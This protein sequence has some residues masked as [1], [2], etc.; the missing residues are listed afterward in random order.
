M[1]GCCRVRAIGESPHLFGEGP[2]R[3]ARDMRV[4]LLRKVP[5]FEVQ[6]PPCAGFPE[7]AESSQI[8]DLTP[9]VVL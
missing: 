5:E 4:D 3:M 8:S 9:S 2:R 7:R 6:A 1:R